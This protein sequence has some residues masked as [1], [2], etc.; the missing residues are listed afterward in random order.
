MI[1]TSSWSPSRRAITIALVAAIAAAVP[2]RARPGALVFPTVGGQVSEW[3]TADGAQ[4]AHFSPL[5]D[6]TRASVHAL[7]I[8][9][10]YRTGDV[11]DGSDGQAGTAFEATPIMVDGVLYL[12]TPSS[13]VI[14]LRAETGQ[15]LWT[16]DPGLDRTDRNQ[17]MVTSRG[18]SAWLDP[19]RSEGEPCRRR[20]FLAAFDARLFALDG[21]RGTPCADF[22][23]E[24][25]VDLRAGV[26]RIEGRR[27]D[28]K[29]TA[30]PTVVGDVVV[31]GSAI[32]DGLH[33][34]APS[35][36]V[37]A[38]DARTGAL[39][40]SWEPLVGVGGRRAGRRFRPRGGRQRL[41]HPHRRRGARPRLRA[42]GQREPRPLG[43]AAAGRQPLRQ[44]PGRAAGLHRRARLALPDGA[45]RPLGLRPGRAGRAHHRDAAEDAR[46]PPWRR[47]R[48]WATSS[49]S[50]ARRESHSSPSSSAPCPRA[51]CPERRPRPRSPSPCSRGRSSRSGCVRRTPGASPPIDRVACRRKIE[52]LRSDG[53]FTPPSLRG[54]IVYPGFIGGM[55]WGGVAF[56]PRSGLLVTNTNR[57]ATVATLIPARRGGDAGRGRR[58]QG[59]GDPADPRALRRPARDPRVAPGPPVQS[60]AVGGAPRRGHPHRRGPLGGAPGHPARRL[61]RALSPP[62]GIGQPGRAGDHRR[63]RLHR[64]HHGPTHPGV[65]PRDRRTWCGSAR[66][67]RPRKPHR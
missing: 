11:S 54:S 49:S 42:H 58:H 8:A 2:F 19:S 56:D 45:P 44:L 17:K 21:R 37:R 32:L 39:R 25:H 41:G 28:Y 4:G 67:P 46:S 57:V 34:D 48:R 26:E 13:R 23:R 7:E 63:A 5:T 55:E 43:R 64:R 27:E 14:A 9:W 29:E 20:I 6:I 60:S 38:F 30:P 50:I 61:G 12:S 33:A 36:V 3:P 53:I 16:F 65:R 35:G 66:C 18:V 59:G 62:M 24:G 51:T 1:Q 47:G 52:G 22:G 15:E 40:W 31:V 10:T